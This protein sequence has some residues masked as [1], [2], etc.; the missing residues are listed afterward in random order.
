MGGGDAEHVGLLKTLSLVFTLCKHVILTTAKLF[1]ALL[2]LQDELDFP[3]VDVFC[4]PNGAGG[5]D[6]EICRRD[7]RLYFLVISTTFLLPG[8]P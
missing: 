1:L 3:P 5:F 2:M 6:V 7:S 4:V 8:A